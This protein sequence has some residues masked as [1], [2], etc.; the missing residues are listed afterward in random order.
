MP[1]KA[2][3]SSQQSSARKRPGPRSPLWRLRVWQLLIVFGLLAIA[4]RLYYLQVV[5]GPE[6]TKKAAIQREQTNLLIHRGAITD[7]HGLPL[8]IDTTRYDVYV[9]PPL[10]KVSKDLAAETFAR[11]CHQDFKKIDRLMHS[12]FP[13]VTIARHLGRE[14]IEELQ[15]LNWTGIDIVPRSF[16]HYPEGNL[17]SHILG[18][19]NM[20]T[21]GQGGIEQ[22]QDT[23]LQN[24]GGIRKPQLD[25]HGRPIL[26]GNESSVTDITP[27]MGHH[28]EL[29]I[30]NYLQHLAEKEL[31]AM[32]IHS[33]AQKGCAI[34][35]DP[36]TGEILAWA[37]YPNYDPNQYH[38]YA[39]EVTKNWAMVDVYQPG[40]TFKI[41]TV[42]AGLDLG[43]IKKN[44]RFA[45]SGS[46]RVGNRTLHNHEPGGHGMIDLLQLFI[47]S[48][49]V[50]SAQIGLMMTPQQFYTKLSEFGLGSVTGVELAGESA[51][52]L[53]N[54]KEWQ[55][56]DSA[57]TGFGQGAIA[58]TPLQLVQAVGV[59]CNGGMKIQ[60]HMIRRVYDPRTGVTER[61]TEPRKTRV[62]S[63]EVSRH[64][65]HLLCENVSIGTQMAGK[66]PGYRVGGKTGTAQKVT[67]NGRGYIA[68]ATIASFIG[69]LPEENPQLLCLV[70]VDSPQTDG[71]WGNTIAG[72][73]FNA[74]C[75]E[76]ARYLGV[77]PAGGIELDAKKKGADT[78][79]PPSV[80]YAAELQSH[81]V[82]GGDA[83]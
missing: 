25:G 33:H 40:S 3:E 31:S 44:T 52:L 18:Y 21:R 5:K 17:A 75:I 32:C 24:T 9:H 26:T 42:A 16:R 23:N 51:G 65:T 49:N 19:V 43:V 36:Q 68:G 22:A 74:I 57:T 34:L 35:T 67:A 53:R 30:D 73:V 81:K 82:G 46:L 7:R 55:P 4:V 1:P 79:V 12:D 64:V 70:V 62:I 37:N 27:P 15:D 10:I 63:P 83:R 54:Y 76:A 41:V 20:D 45:D 80:K 38:K 47:H 59:V 28:V 60:P 77:P 2:M 13:V 50:A 29:T 39:Y 61:W 69:F 56:I 66:V 11:I 8:A 6:L 14:E 48:S 78:F 72:P 58:V 71:R